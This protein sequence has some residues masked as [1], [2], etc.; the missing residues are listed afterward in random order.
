MKNTDTW[1]EVIVIA[2][3]PNV[4]GV[5]YP[6]EEL[7]LAFNKYMKQEHRY[8]ELNQSGTKLDIDRISHELKNVHFEGNKLYGEIAVLNTPMGNAVKTL[9]AEMG[10]NFTLGLCATAKLSTE[11]VH[12]MD[13]FAPNKLYQKAA[14]VTVIGVSVLEKNKTNH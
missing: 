13:L 8:G 5:I 4:N 3:E 14:D 10:S 6:R 12:S 1:D 11:P 2:D 7:E 9:L